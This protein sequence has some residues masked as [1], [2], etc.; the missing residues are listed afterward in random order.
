MRDVQVARTLMVSSAPAAQRDPLSEPRLALLP[1]ASVL[2]D[3]PESDGVGRL[4]RYNFKLYSVRQ[5]L[6]G[7]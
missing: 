6:S 4:D 7:K 2:R 5:R 3:V 1:D